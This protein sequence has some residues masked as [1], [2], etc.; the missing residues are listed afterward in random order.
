MYLP[1]QFEEP[2]A[3][4]MHG[5]VRA[6]PLATLVT[7]SSSGLIAN[8]IPLYLSASPAPFGTLQGHVAR[9]N[10][11]LSDLTEEIETLALFHG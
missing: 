2:R 10:P 5:L 1:E 11:L 9:A 7:R 4:V 6:H 8:H 3:E